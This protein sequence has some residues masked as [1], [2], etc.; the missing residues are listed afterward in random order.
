MKKYLIIILFY[1][2]NTTAQTLS[3]MPDSIRKIV[4]NYNGVGNFSKKPKI[5]NVELSDEDIIKE[6]LLYFALNNDQI[7][8]A[9]ANVL[10]SKIARKKANTSML[11]SV[12]LG[13]NINE[14]AITNSKVATLFP[15]YNL[16]LAVPLDI[17]AR[18]KAEKNTADQLILTSEFQKKLLESNLKSK[19][20]IQYETYKEKLALLQ[21]QKISM[22]D[23]LA[24]YELAQKNFKDA[25]ITMD[26]LNKIYRALT[27]EKAF[28]ATKEKDLNIVIIQLEEIIGV[29]LKSVLA[30]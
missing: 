30:K 10:I 22:E 24:D 3:K 1:G 28:L 5:P 6:K 16:G 21:Y 12:T 20:L 11:S 7:K 2:H 27:G 15:K 4:D 9:A 14:F 18:N 19:V 13:A 17:F 26:E 23:N 8:E 25:I 29:P